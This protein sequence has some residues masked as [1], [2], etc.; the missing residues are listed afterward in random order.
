MKITFDYFN[1]KDIVWIEFHRNKVT[2]YKSNRKRATA[3]QKR[4]RSAGFFRR[5][6]QVVNGGYIITYKLTPIG[7]LTS[8]GWYAKFLTER[9]TD[10]VWKLTRTDTTGPQGEYTV[11]MLTRYLAPDY[12]VIRSRIQ[13]APM[14]NI[15]YIGM[16]KRKH[17]LFLTVVDGS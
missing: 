16:P 13:N 10:G 17:K 4:L 5:S 6:K 9:F 11:T 8:K 1:N 3:L 12:K 15:I 14:P 2:A 7:V